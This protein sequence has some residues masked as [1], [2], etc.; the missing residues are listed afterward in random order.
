MP[1]LTPLAADFKR[2]LQVS[3][4]LIGIST[5]DPAATLHELSDSFPKT[6]P[7]LW[8]D[9][10][11]GPRVLGDATIGEAALARMKTGAQITVN[12]QLV[13]LPTFLDA[14]RFAPE[15][16]IFYLANLHLYWD[17]P[18]VRQA[19]WNARDLFK[20]DGRAFVALGPALTAPPELKGDIMLFEQAY[21]SRPKIET[22][23]RKQCENAKLPEPA[24]DV[25][26]KATDAMTGIEPFMVEQVSALAAKKNGLDVPFMQDRRCQVIAA[27]RGLS[28]WRGPERFS[29]IGGNQSVKRYIGRLIA[30]NAFGG[31]VWIDEVADA[32][33][34][35][36]SEGSGVAGDQHLQLITWMA[37]RKIPAILLVGQ[38]GTGKSE[39]SK[40]TGNEAGRPTIRF[41]MGGMMGQYV[42]N[43]QD[44]I[45]NAIKI[46][47]AVTAGRPLV[48]ATA[49]DT[50]SLSPQ[51]MSR[52]MAVFYFDLPTAD[53][54]PA[55]WTIQLAKY[56]ITAAQQDGLDDL[57]A[58]PWTGREIYRCCEQAA[59]LSMSLR[60]AAECVVPISQS[61]PERIQALRRAA[62]KHFLS[63][64]YPGIFR[65]DAVE[66]ASAG[67]RRIAE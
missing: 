45:R 65:I 1:E 28:V 32:M 11:R 22:I 47:D 40:A 18:E 7:V 64:A 15:L 49:N 31:S 61:Q 53:E 20:Q 19:L 62:D 54:L 46:V 10:V 55:I 33:R 57:M 42:G 52:F 34:G 14:A 12:A 60:E 4:P 35:H 67:G 66:A 2:A 56:G 21:P 6:R 17:K 3:T 8:W 50:D 44:Y 27:T 59:L 43:S 25:L 37:D 9:V 23:I 26:G 48:L 41:D 13:V 51:F 5:P 38:P 58:R 36:Q 30:S 63:A 24:A 29:A 39:I 16:T